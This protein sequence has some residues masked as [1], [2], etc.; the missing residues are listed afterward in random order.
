MSR[1]QQ[2]ERIWNVMWKP[3]GIR[4]ARGRFTYGLAGRNPAARTGVSDPDQNT[5]EVC[6]LPWT[7]RGEGICAVPAN[8]ARIRVR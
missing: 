2:C 8:S 1:R 6:S 4:V 7:G 5:V 3:H